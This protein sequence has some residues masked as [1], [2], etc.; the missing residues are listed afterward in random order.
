MKPRLSYLD[1]HLTSRERKDIALLAL[2]F[3]CLLGIKVVQRYG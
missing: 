3:A 2:T 1:I